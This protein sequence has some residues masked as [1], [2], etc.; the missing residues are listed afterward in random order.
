MA[1]GTETLEN[2]V[3]NMT[4]TDDGDPIGTVFLL[5][6]MTHGPPAL[7]SIIKMV[8]TAPSPSSVSSLFLAC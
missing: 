8:S 1:D 3:R 5:N 6:D 4:Q 2:S 7:V